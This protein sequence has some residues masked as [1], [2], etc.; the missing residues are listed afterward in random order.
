MLRGMGI[1]FAAVVL[2]G[3]IAHD[4][5]AKTMRRPITDFTD[6]QCTKTA[7][8]WEAI[9]ESGF[10]VNYVAWTGRDAGNPNSDIDM[11]AVVDY[12]GCESDPDISGSVV[13]RELKDGRTEVHVTLHARN[14][15]TYVREV[16]FLGEY[17]FLVFGD[18]LFGET[19]GSALLELTYVVDRPV[20]GEMNDLVATIFLGLGDLG[21]IDFH[22][23]AAGDLAD[24]TS[25]RMTVIETGL[26]GAGIANGFKGALG[27][28]FPVET[29]ILQPVGN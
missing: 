12:A 28:A 22:A 26:I 4:A 6:A 24:G 20:G 23:N 13:E 14:A 29:I 5:R 16:A 2:M 11:I 1:A 25:G 7:A 17:P 18:T 21:V 27:D 3:L 9:L 8:E 15:L 19:T 10:I